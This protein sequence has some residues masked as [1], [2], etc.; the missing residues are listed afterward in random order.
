MW[1]SDFFTWCTWCLNQKSSSNNHHVWCVVIGRMRLLCCPWCHSVAIESLL[2]LTMWSWPYHILS[3]NVPAGRFRL[4]SGDT[5]YAL[6]L[7]GNSVWPTLIFTVWLVL[8]RIGI[9]FDVREQIG[10]FV[11]MTQIIELLWNPY[12]M[13]YMTWLTLWERGLRLPWLA[14]IHSLCAIYCTYTDTNIS[15]DVPW[16]WH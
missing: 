1:P 16:H 4:I 8:A 2:S 10:G 7:N 14:I 12:C 11:W 6:F 9:W 13:T 3:N 15:L 5:W